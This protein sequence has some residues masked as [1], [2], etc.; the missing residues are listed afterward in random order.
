MAVI[1]TM[2][3]VVDQ[4]VSRP[5]FNLV[6]LGVFAAVSLL[7]AE[8]G[9]YGILANAVRMRTQEIGIRMALGA[10]RRDV[11]RL[12]VGQGMRMA[13]LGVSLGL[14]GALAATR[15]LGGM[16]YQV[17]PL[18][19]LTFAVVSIGLLAVAT[20]ASY[21][22]ARNASRVDPMIALRHE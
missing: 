7:L 18:D 13:I 9:I 15:L 4:T 3:E 5:R 21:L 22:P 2:D 12:V 16:L 10:S 11:V 19:S 14:A 1:R 8:I 20:L 17:R 6:L